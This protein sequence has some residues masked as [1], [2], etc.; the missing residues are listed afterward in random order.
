M[1]CNPDQGARKFS[2]PLFQLFT[3]V[4]NSETLEAICQLW[5]LGRRILTA[6]VHEG[7]YEVLDCEVK[8][9]LS[10]RRGKTAVFHKQER[11]RFLQDNI[12]A[13][14]DPVWGDGEIFADYQCS[15]GVEADRYQAGHRWWVLISLRETK[16]HGDKEEFHIRRTI[17]DGF[18]QRH[19]SF[20][21][22]VNHKTRRLTMSVI[23]PKN[24]HPQ[25]V[26]LVEQNRART[27]TLGPKHLIWLPDGRLQ[28]TWR[29]TRPRLFEAYIMKWEW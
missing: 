29:T 21:M 17:R 16:N 3:L 18:T 28:A 12:I 11:V 27:M 19:E 1:V 4:L 2:P 6:Q 13:Y 25:R 24:R 26:S 22:E 14:Q 8:L 20:Q 7:M 23:F 9:E 5:Q 10:D 15:P